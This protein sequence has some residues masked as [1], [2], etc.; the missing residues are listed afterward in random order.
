M[1]TVALSTSSRLLL[2]KMGI[3]TNILHLSRYDYIYVKNILKENDFL[4]VQL[5]TN[6]VWTNGNLAVFYNGYKLG[7][8]NSGIGKVVL[9]L[10]EKF[11]DVKVIVKKIPKKSNPFSGIDILIQIC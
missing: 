10:I 2:P 9:R 7:Y 8:L 11:G 6:R 5:E 4:T 3:L 1:E